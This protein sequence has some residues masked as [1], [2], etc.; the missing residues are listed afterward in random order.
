MSNSYYGTEL[1]EERW[2][3]LEHWA[4]PLTDEQQASVERQA[5]EAEDRAEAA[6]P[7]VERALKKLA[8][9][10]PSGDAYAFRV[11]LDTWELEAASRAAQQKLLAALAKESLLLRKS[12]LARRTALRQHPLVWKAVKVAS[13][14]ELA[15]VGIE[16]PQDLGDLL[17]PAVV[18]RF[19][20]DVPVGEEA[21][22]D[23]WEY[24]ESDQVANA[25]NALLDLKPEEIV[26]VL[27]ESAQPRLRQLF[28]GEHVG[29]LKEL[30]RDDI[31][32]YAPFLAEALARRRAGRADV[33][34]PRARGEEAGEE[35]A[36][37]HGVAFAPEEDRFEAL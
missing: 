24:E 14:S 20:G 9:L 36:L 5:R 13:D 12:K 6:R 27:R 15:K 11:N 4:P 7:L 3:P 26:Q 37:S 34:L 30:I 19:L 31:P 10:A 32:L 8:A 2:K 21:I 16:D 1:D 23:S 17:T 18:E 25:F 28:D 33:D 35:P 29:Q 22:Q